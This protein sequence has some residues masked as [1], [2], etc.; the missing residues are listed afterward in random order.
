M[1]MTALAMLGAAALAGCG[2]GRDN[3]STRGAYVPTASGPI[4]RACL[5]SDRRSANPVLCGCIQSVADRTLSGGDQ[6]RGAAWFS[7]PHEAQVTR[8][9]DRARDERLWDA[10]KIFADEAE[11]SCG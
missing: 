1:R 11:R 9:S 2:G 4:S 10:W 3:V 8:Q 5:A 6:R 7:D